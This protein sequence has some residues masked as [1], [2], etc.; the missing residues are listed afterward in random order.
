MKA[1][2]RFFVRL[3]ASITRRLDEKRLREEIEEHLAL[4]TA[5]NIKAGMSPGEARRQSVLKF[6]AIE[7]LKED[8]RDKRGLPVLERG[9]H[10]IRYAVRSLYKNPG[11]TTV[12]VLT[13]MLG[14]GANTAMFSLIDGLLFKKLPVENPHEL[15]VLRPED[16]NE[17]QAFTYPTWERLQE[18]HPAPFEGLFAYA[19]SRLNSES[20]AI[21]AMRASSAMF[22]TLGNS[23]ALGRVFTVGDDQ[24]G[25][26]AV[27]MIT[28]R[29]WQRRFGGARDVIGRTIKIEATP[30]TIVGVT[31]STFLGPTIGRTFDVAIPIGTEPLIRGKG[32]ESFRRTFSW[33]NVMGRLKSGN[34]IE[35]ATSALRG[36]QADIRQQ[37][38]PVVRVRTNGS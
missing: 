29:Y 17:P 12:A 35:A 31:P 4:Q 6:G 11:F 24:R 18:S 14:I 30:F 20:D 3:T 28:Y 26:G 13:L 25:G 8:Y 9:L 5:E 10:D 38:M 23:P 7:A 16:A 21:D 34:T 33:L 36:V 1:L 37:S 15:V 19:Y 27:A 2:R 32:F 22:T